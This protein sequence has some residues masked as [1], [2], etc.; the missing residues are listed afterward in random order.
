MNHGVVTMF[1]CTFS[2]SLTPWYLY[3]HKLHINAA[4]IRFQQNH[5]AFQTFNSWMWECGLN[6]EVKC[7]LFEQFRWFNMQECTVNCSIGDTRTKR[8]VTKTDLANFHP[9]SHRPRETHNCSEQGFP[10]HL[11]WYRLLLW[12]QMFIL[13]IGMVL[14]LQE[15]LPCQQW[16]RPPAH[17]WAAATF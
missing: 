9:F 16:A 8:A 10:I 2:V 1:T 5:P 17:W 12:K 15:D 3:S 13:F 6:V 4:F 11:T 7:Q 14:C